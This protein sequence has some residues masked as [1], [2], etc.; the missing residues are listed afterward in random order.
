MHGGRVTCPA[1]Q[2]RVLVVSLPFSLMELCDD[3]VPAL[4]GSE[5]KGNVLVGLDHCP[6]LLFP[7]LFF[8]LRNFSRT[9]TKIMG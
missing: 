1:I 7:V 6:T 8:E 2:Q 5:A 3:I 9:V 4:D